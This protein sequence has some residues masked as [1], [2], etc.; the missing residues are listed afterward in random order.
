[1]KRKYEILPE[2]HDDLLLSFLHKVI[3]F[4]VKALAIL[5]VFVI[6]WGVVDVVYVLFEHLK[7]PPFMLLNLSDML[8]VFATFL[9]VLIAIEIYQNIVLYLHTDIIPVKLV[10]AT[11]LMAV[12]RKIII[13]DSVEATPLYIISIG[14]V[15]LSLGITYFLLEKKSEKE[16]VA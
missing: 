6:L 8:R 7:K 15:V 2:K 13:I 3:K 5:M 12:A 1:M 10:I 16:E 14:L 11:A 4:S 9:T